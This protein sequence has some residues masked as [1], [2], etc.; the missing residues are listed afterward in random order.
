[1]FCSPSTPT[2]FVPSKAAPSRKNAQIMSEQD[3]G[4]DDQFL[5]CPRCGVA[6]FYIEKPEG[7]L[8]FFKVTFDK[9]PVFENP[10]DPDLP[11]LDLS[12]IYCTACAWEGTFSELVERPPKQEA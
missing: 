5:R 9:K 8:V 12:T 2:T 3:N 4:K 10:S 1:L 11:D 6:T 7:G